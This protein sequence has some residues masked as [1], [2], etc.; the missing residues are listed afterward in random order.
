MVS[1]HRTESD[2]TGARDS[3]LTG[4]C[5]LC[6]VCCLNRIPKLFN[7]PCVSNRTKQ[8]KEHKEH[9]TGELRNQR[10]RD[11]NLAKRR[12]SRLARG[13]LERCWNGLGNA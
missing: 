7:V 9:R 3:V 10:R 6:R 5:C 8:H 1:G 4:R 12:T 2:G 11:S 13:R